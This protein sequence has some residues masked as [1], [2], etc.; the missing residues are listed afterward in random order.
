MIEE[1]KHSHENRFKNVENYLSV[2]IIIVCFSFCLLALAVFHHY[3]RWRYR[4]YLEKKGITRE[5]LWYP[6]Y[7]NHLKNL[8]I[9]AMIANFVIV[10]ILVE[11]AN[12]SSIFL[13]RILILSKENRVTWDIL[14]HIRFVTKYS[15]IPIICMFLD[16]LWLAYLHSQYRFTIKRWIAYIVLRLIAMNITYQLARNYPRTVLEHKFNLTMVRIQL[17]TVETIDFFTYIWYARRFYK[18]LKGRE[19]EARL[20]MSRRKYLENRFICRHFKIATTL[21]SI[22]LSIYFLINVFSLLSTLYL[23]LHYLRIINNSRWEHYAHMIVLWPITI[24]QLLFRVL[25]NLNYVYFMV[26]CGFKYWIQKRNLNRVN[27]HI[28]PLV[29]R[30]Q[31]QIYARNHWRM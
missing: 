5:Q 7:Q 16:V 1:K 2:F 27:D 6:C 19:L 8:K 3:V 28:K 22:S 17:M 12:N 23:I 11:I 13:E 29:R 10:I 31:E 4:L 20:F 24:C 14:N 26:V 21:V 30:Y 18:L 25:F 15:F 9:K